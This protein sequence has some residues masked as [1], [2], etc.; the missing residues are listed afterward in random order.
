VR[1][2]DGTVRVLDSGNTLPLGV[3]GGAQPS[4]FTYALADG[5]TL[6]LYTD[7]LVERRSE[8]IDAGIDRLMTSLGGGPPSAA[9]T[10]DRVLERLVGDQPPGDDVA[11]LAVHVLPLDDGPLRL[12]LPARPES[13][14]IARHRLREWLH[15]EFPDL[16]GIVASDL[17]VAFSEACTNV[18]RHA[19]GPGDALFRAGAAALGATVELSVEDDGC[20][21]PPRGGHGGRGIELM[22]A[23]CDEVAIEHGPDGTRVSMRRSVGR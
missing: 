1:A 16:D 5:D 10:C 8:P 13:V 4:E 22:R 19:Y 6:L 18:V 11:L 21:R 23:L 2:A 20:W 9:E 3:I 14:T 15:H 7:G 17:E 12:E